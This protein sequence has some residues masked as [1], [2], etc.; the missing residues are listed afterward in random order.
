M[1]LSGN[2]LK[3]KLIEDYS[4]K[5]DEIKKEF[6][7]KGKDFNK[8][9]IGI[10]S[11]IDDEPS[12]VYLKQL[13]KLFK[14]FDLNYEIIEISKNSKNGGDKN[15]IEYINNF[16]LRDDIIGIFVQM[17]MVDVKEKEYVINAISPNKDLEGITRNSF[18]SI[19]YNKEFLVP[20]TA[21]AVIELANYYNI[22]FAS[23]DVLI[24]NRSYIIG[25]PL[26]GLL[27]NRDATVT[28]AHS[29]TKDLKFKMKESEI[30]ITAV[31]K[32]CF[33]KKEDIKKGTIIFDLSINYLD[34]K[35]V[36]DCDFESLKDIC[37]ITPV[38][39]G[40]GPITNLMLIKN[41]LNII[42]I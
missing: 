34:N 6:E 2:E 7:K 23:K 16:N 33:I 17:P 31:G 26:I 4:F 1:I 42:K 37:S 27:L 14:K 24:I 11:N 41:Y 29:K 13:L 40:V 21:N 18:A 32:P 20:P 30:I 36:G 9:K 8:N 38:P 10:L 5:I 3:K 19:F 39:D 35:I 22:N 15:Y 25:K 12:R 28:V